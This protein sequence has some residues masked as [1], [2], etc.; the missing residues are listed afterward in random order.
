MYLYLIIIF[1]LHTRYVG[2]IKKKLLAYANINT[3]GKIYVYF[4]QEVSYTKNRRGS[5]F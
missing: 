2:K 5:S 4:N 1:L 3:S